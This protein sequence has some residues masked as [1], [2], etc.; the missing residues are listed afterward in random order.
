MVGVGVDKKLN[1][2][3]CFFA[4]N[5]FELKSYLRTKLGFKDIFMLL[6]FNV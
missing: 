1:G 5:Y 2:L 3:Y 6:N 4:L